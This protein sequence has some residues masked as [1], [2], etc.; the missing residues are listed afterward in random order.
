M[1]LLIIRQRH[2]LLFL[3]FIPSGE[4]NGIIRDVYSLSNFIKRNS[5]IVFSN[6]RYRII[7]KRNKRNGYERGSIN[8]ICW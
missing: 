1:I 3:D 8:Q 5:K 6:R 4:I 7:Q 2:T